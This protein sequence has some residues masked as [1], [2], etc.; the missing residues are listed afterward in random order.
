MAQLPASFRL[1]SAQRPLISIEVRT[2]R[3]PSDSAQPCSLSQITSSENSQTR[4]QDSQM[5]KA[6]MALP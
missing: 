5:P 3:K 2:G 6:I 4:A 1:H